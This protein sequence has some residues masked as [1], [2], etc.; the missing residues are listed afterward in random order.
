MK[1]DHTI[2]VGGLSFKTTDESLRVYF[3]AAAEV[4]SARV[5]RDP[6]GR[7]RGYGFVSF[8]DAAA[9]ANVMAELDRSELD[10][11]AVNLRPAHR[12]TAP[13]APHPMAMASG[14]KPRA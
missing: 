12:W 6:E 10:G 3:D 5:A 1:P 8:R 14:L 4:V 7:S 11:R 2:F 13:S 9:A